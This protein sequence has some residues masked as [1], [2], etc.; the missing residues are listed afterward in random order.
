MKYK[1]HLPADHLWLTACI[2]HVIDWFL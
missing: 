2:R 1:V